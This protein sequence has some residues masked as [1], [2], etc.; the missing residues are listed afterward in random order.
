MVLVGTKCCRGRQE[1]CV[2]V[3]TLEPILLSWDPVLGHR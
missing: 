2:Q 1:E 3:P